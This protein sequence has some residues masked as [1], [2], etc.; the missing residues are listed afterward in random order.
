MRELA[1]RASV[2]QPFLSNVENGRISP[3]VASLYALAGALGVSPSELM[4]AIGAA[5]DSAAGVHLPTHDSD[6]AHDVRVLSAG[7]GRMLEG[8][9]FDVGAD[10]ADPAY[11]EHDGEDLVHVLAGAV[12]LERPGHEDVT[13][14][15]GDSL[16]VDARTPHRWRAAAPAEQHGGVRFLLTSANRSV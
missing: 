1:R 11:F 2:S 6:D 16:W 7:G 8:Y 5:G 3:S 15:A 14:D 13:V 10:Y 12:V 4:P 9:L